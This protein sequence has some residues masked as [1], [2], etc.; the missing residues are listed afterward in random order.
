MASSDLIRRE[1]LI[2]SRKN[3]TKAT[4]MNGRAELDSEIL[5]NHKEVVRTERDDGYVSLNVVTV[6][7]SEK[8]RVIIDL[9]T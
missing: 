8:T 3:P 5:Q 4:I 2:Q 9:T 1:A 7:E 6:S